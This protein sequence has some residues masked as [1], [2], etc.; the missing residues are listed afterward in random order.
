MPDWWPTLLLGV[1]ATHLP[2]F[3][4]RWHRSGELRYAATTV[5]FV[6]LVATYGLQVFAP[7]LRIAEVE[8]QPWLRRSAWA[9]AVLSLGL[10]ARHWLRGLS[11]RRPT[12]A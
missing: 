11:K 9:A 8:L 1:F 5:T 3:A 12:R 6:L 7:E 2:F 4:W 10:L